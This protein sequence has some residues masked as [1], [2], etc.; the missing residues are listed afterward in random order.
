MQAHADVHTERRTRCTRLVL[1]GRAVRVRVLYEKGATRPYDA[2]SYFGSDDGYV[3]CLSAEDGSVIWKFSAAPKDQRVLGHGR[4]ISL[5]PVRSGVLLDG[6]IAYVASGCFP[7]RSVPLRLGMRKR[8][9]LWRNDSCGED[10]KVESP[11]KAT[12]S[13]LRRRLYA[14]MGRVSPAAL[15]G[16]RKCAFYLLRKRPLAGLTPFWSRRWVSYTSTEQDGR[17]RRQDS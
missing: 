16:N 4:M 7:P 10:P 2:R 3:Y 6:G 9:E 17:I 5:W 13:P 1:T 14:P 15:T 12:S 8:R 11:R